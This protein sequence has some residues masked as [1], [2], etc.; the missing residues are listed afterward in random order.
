MSDLLERFWI[1]DLGGYEY[2]VIVEGFLKVTMPLAFASLGVGMV[3][4]LLWAGAKL[5]PYRWVNRPAFALANI[6]RSVPELLI[7]FLIYF[8]GEQALSALFPGISFN[9]FVAGMVAIS[10]VF[11][12]YASE[13]LRGALLAVPFGQ[14]EAARAFGMNRR[15]VF[16]RIQLPQ[17]MRFAL[18]GLGNLWLVLMKDT[19]LVSVVG[20]EDTMRYSQFGANKTKLPFNSF[21]SVAVLY[22]LFTTVSLWLTKYLER[23]T[24]RGVRRTA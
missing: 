10:L 16:L 12:A 24:E 4:G 1:I 14:I 20:L 8:G 17:M 9:R 21:L 13:T 18:P 23:R 5:S 19:S 22:L 7:I 11:A 15:Q 6:G 2:L 3:L